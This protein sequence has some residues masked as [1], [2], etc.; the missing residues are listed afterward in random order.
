MAGGAGGSAPRGIDRLIERVR[1]HYGPLD[2]KRILDF[3]CGTGDDARHL[4]RRHQVWAVESP[5]WFAAT[6]GEP[7]AADAGARFI[8][9]DPVEFAR[10]ICDGRP[11]DGAPP[12]LDVVLFRCSLCR[13]S[14]RALVLQAAHRLLRP[15]GL[16]IATDWVQT[17]VTDRIT[18]SRIVGTGRF[19]DLETEPGYR[20]LCSDQRFTDFVSWDWTTE[21]G[22]TAPAMHRW[23]CARLEDVRRLEDERGRPPRSPHDRAFLLRLRRDLEALAALSTAEGPLGWLFWAARKPLAGD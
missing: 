10:R 3:G 21:P 13:I 9:L 4:A 7:P 23:F 22:A 17:R 6:R 12:P 14:Q 8:E 11:L 1:H 18:W 2:M 19:V 16:V 5:L 20:R 15:G